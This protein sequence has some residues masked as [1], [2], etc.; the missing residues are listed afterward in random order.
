M[1]ETKY[2]PRHRAVKQSAIRQWRRAVAL[3]ATVPAAVG[4]AVTAGAP[5]QAASQPSIHDALEIARNQR[6]EEYQYGADGPNQFDCSG[7]VQYVYGKAGIQ[8]PRTS[9]EQANRVRRIA[10]EDMRPG[11]LMFYY[12]DGGV[13]HVA[14]FGGFHGDGGRHIVHAANESA[15]VTSGMN[16][17]GKWFA[18]TMRGQ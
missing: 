12:D 8:M 18:G 16:W 9:D 11:D 1:S 13:Y 14:V 2:T 10:K 4:A 15:D 5:V 3:G 7:F 17:T 6:G